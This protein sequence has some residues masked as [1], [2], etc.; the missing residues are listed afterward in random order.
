[1][2]SKLEKKKQTI[3]E[4]IEKKIED[5]ERELQKWKELLFMTV[6]ESLDEKIDK[7][8]S[9]VSKFLDQIDLPFK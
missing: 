3:K 7:L 9:Q 5:N 1:M 6:N 2:K 4:I 8:I